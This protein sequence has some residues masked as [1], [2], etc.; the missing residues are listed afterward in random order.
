MEEIRKTL[1]LLPH[2]PGVYLFFN[3]QAAVIYVG[4][5]IDLAH[6]VRSY[7]QKDLPREWKTSEL[8]QQTKRIEIVETVS[9]F[10]A[11]TLE[12]S[13]IRRYLPKYNAI[14][15]DDKSPIYVVITFSEE[16]PR[17]VVT[18]KTQVPLIAKSA[19]DAVFGPFQ[20]AKATRSVLRDLRPIVP[21]CTQKQRNGKPCFYTHL[22]LC[23]PCPSVIAKLVSGGEKDGLIKEY[24][25]HI[26]ELKRA[27]SGHTSALIRS[28]EKE[29]H[30]RAAMHEFEEATVLRNR[31][32]AIYAL[33]Q[34]HHDPSVYLTS[35]G[36][37]DVYESELADLRGTLLPFFPALGVLR[38]IECIDISN[39]LGEYPTGSLV[40]LTDGR[41]DKTWYRRFRIKSV[42]GANDP[43]MIAEIVSRRFKHDEWPLPDLLLVDGGKT[44]VRAAVAALASVHMKL[45]VVGLAKRREE[46]IVPTG[47]SFKIIRLNLS[48]AGLH[49]LERVRDEAH[50]FALRYHRF[51]RESAL[52]SPTKLPHGE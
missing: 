41:P 21:F 47:T 6:R 4:K 51:L 37:R 12:A 14:L 44:Q 10:D 1:K 49:V 43:A 26:Y 3:K 39:I 20:S 40:V 23:R 7:F 31:I 19:Q 36:A 35:G 22:G 30:R 17:V 33:V 46:I 9:E 27:L 18:R 45:P 28:L 16:L 11:L 29:M 52:L 32:Q 15:R 13:L 48:R 2:R 25:K 5:A 50:R 8:R 38:R 24:R 34:K 42:H